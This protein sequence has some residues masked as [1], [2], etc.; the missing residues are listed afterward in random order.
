M[1]IPIYNP[2]I[3]P[4]VGQGTVP[5]E[6]NV[7][8]PV[9]LSVLDT[10]AGRTESA[11]LDV[12]RRENYVNDLKA[13]EEFVNQ[14]YQSKIDFITQLDAAEQR[15]RRGEAD[16]DTGDVITP[17]ATGDNYATKVQESFDKIRNDTLD[18]VN[19]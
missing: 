8:G 5:F 3:D 19:P 4:N 2:Q 18:S 7:Q 9:S 12:L 16:P 1:R 6:T 11:A 10:A 14:A 15:V 13:H 17:P